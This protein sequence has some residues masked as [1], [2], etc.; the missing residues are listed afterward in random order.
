MGNINVVLIEFSMFSIVTVMVASY[1]LTYI[2]KYKHTYI[3]TYTCMLILVARLFSKN[4]RGTPK[5]YPNKDH[6]TLITISTFINPPQL[7]I[8]CNSPGVALFS[9]YMYDHFGMPIT[10]L[11]KKYMTT[12][13]AAIAI[14]SL[15]RFHCFC[16]CTC[17]VVSTYF[18][19]FFN[20]M[21][22]SYL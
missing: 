1:C 18:L 15:D 6:V 21:L 22:Y 11:Q 4:I 16:C 17:L 19:C 8:Y 10:Y 9:K 5:E 13:P 20:A 3:H 2:H 14:C 7:I 12:P